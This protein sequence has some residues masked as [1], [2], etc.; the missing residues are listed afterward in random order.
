MELGAEFLIKRYSKWMFGSTNLGV[1]GSDDGPE[2]GDGDL[3]LVFGTAFVDL[4]EGFF[5]ARV[6]RDDPFELRLVREV[7]PKS[8]IEYLID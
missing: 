1:F 6:A 3:S 7:V 8:Y 5:V 4:N 2:F